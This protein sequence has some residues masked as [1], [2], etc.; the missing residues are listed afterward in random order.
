M[1]YGPPNDLAKENFAKGGHVA[2]EEKCVCE[3]KRGKN[4]IQHT[5]VL[6]SA[7]SVEPGKVT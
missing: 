6:P 2:E 7:T 3:K 5:K 4:K 1:A